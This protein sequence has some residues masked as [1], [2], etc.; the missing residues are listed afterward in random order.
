MLL[1]N[2]VFIVCFGIVVLYCGWGWEMVIEFVICILVVW[3]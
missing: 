1:F 3:D 2:C